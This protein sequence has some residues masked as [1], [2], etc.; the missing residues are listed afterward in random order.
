MIAWCL[1]MRN[2]AIEGYQGAKKHHNKGFKASAYES[3]KGKGGGL[4]YQILYSINYIVIHYI[5][6]MQDLTPILFINLSKEAKGRR[7]C[8][9]ILSSYMNEL[10]LQLKSFY[11]P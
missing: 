1:I 5:L 10:L 2:I 6:I 3:T 7:V 4:Y 8:C 9:Q 11:S